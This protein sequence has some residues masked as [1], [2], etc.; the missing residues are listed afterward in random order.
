M[1]RETYEEKRKK[2]PCFKENETLYCAYC[3]PNEESSSEATN[4]AEED[5]YVVEQILN[6]KINHKR[7]FKILWQIDE[8]ISW[9]PEPE[10]HNCFGLLKEYCL[11]KKFAPPEGEEKFGASGPGSS[12]HNTNNFIS[13][14]QVLHKAGILLRAENSKIKVEG[15]T[16][17]K[18]KDQ[19]FILG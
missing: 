6:H 2:K 3:T 10:L 5:Y 19:L 9:L 17:L 15:F 12:K 16:K 18:E 14:E 7:S 8:S 11:R 13:L 1:D 4:T